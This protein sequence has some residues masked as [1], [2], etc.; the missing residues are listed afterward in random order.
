LV[1]EAEFEKEMAQQKNRSRAA[2]ALDTEDW[3]V[4]KEGPTKFIGYEVLS[5]TTQL[6]KYRKATAKGKTSYQLLLSETPFYAESGGQVGDTGTLLFGEESIV[7]TDTKKE[8]DLVIHCTDALPA[9]ISPLLTANVNVSRRTAIAAHHSATHLLQA[10]L[11]EVLGNHVAQKGSLVNDAALRFDFTHFA[12]LTPEEIAAVETRVNEKIRANIPV[13]IQ[14]MPKQAAIDKGAMALF[15]EKYADT[16]RV[17][18]IDPTYSIELCG[19]THVA[20]TGQLG[21]F[22]ITHET[23]VAAGVR[24]I[25]AVCGLAA[26]Q[27]IHQQLQ[28]LQ[29]VSA[30][31]K[32]PKLIGK[33]IENLFTE[34]ADLQKRLA[35][36]ENNLLADITTTLLKQELTVN[37]IRFIAAVVNVPHAEALKKLCTNL[38]QQAQDYVAVLCANINGKPFVALGIAETIATAKNLDAAKIIKEKVTPLIKGGGGGQKTFATAGGQDP[39]GLEKVIAA[40]KAVL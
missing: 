21:H 29:A 17:V 22:K 10:A 33:A 8:N 25:E 39:L 28:E 30:Q 35:Q 40:V 16:V 2:T 5:T 13:L 1:N 7:I 27:Y 4:V 20:Q 19:G 38:S 6:L 3:T 31:L 26:E 37:N 12:K 32:H 24:R 11:R 23:A 18:M 34:N 36:L 9:T 15:G 14:T